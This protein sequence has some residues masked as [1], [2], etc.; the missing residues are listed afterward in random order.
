MQ[1]PND[2]LISP[3]FS[4]SRHL[5]AILAL[6]LIAAGCSKAEDPPP[7][8][9]PTAVEVVDGPGF[10][11]QHMWMFFDITGMDASGNTESI[12]DDLIAE[13]SSQAGEPVALTEFLNFSPLPDIEAAMVSPDGEILEEV[14]I[15]LDRKSTRLN[16]SHVAISYAVVCL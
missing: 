11:L 16:S 15:S 2:G 12:L 7:A 8:P 5:A 6:V 1:Y 4:K 9:A 13:V 3:F 14:E 10:H